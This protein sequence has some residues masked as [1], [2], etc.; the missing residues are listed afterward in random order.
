MGRERVRDR[1]KQREREGERLLKLIFWETYG[2]DHRTQKICLF[3]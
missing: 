3:P 1:E 2:I